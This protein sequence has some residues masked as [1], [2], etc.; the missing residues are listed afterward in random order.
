MPLSGGTQREAAA[1]LDERPPRR[2]ARGPDPSLPSPARRIHSSSAHLL[3]VCLH[4]LQR[5]KERRRLRRR[6]ALNS[7]RACEEDDEERWRM[8]R[9]G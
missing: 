6:R 1:Y 8:A 9:E 5:V 2:S 7:R 4:L 3:S